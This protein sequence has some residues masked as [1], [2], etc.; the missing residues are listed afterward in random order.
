MEWNIPIVAGAAAGACIA[1]NIGSAAC[2]YYREKH[3][4]EPKAVFI[5]PRS[6]F[7]R[8]M[9][10]FGYYKEDEI[11][12]EE[13][14]DWVKYNPWPNYNPDHAFGRFATRAGYFK[15]KRQE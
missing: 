6:D 4:T 1:Y 12:N 14:A 15:L 8:F 11:Y 3:P 2:S 9:N 10:S 13:L 5:D 7:E